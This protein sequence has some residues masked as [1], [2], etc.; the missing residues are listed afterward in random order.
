MVGKRKNYNS[1]CETCP[2]KSKKLEVRFGEF[3]KTVLS[4]DCRKQ[5]VIYI[6]FCRICRQQGCETLY[7]G[8]CKKLIKNRFTNA[9]SEL[10]NF[11]KKKSNRHTN[12]QTHFVHTHNITDPYLFQKEIEI[13]IISEPIPNRTERED[14]ETTWKNELK[15][16]ARKMTKVHVLNK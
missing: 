14:T 13:A 9:R 15:E 2:S 6:V 16:A 3:K 1:C 7:I 4:W 5:F 12:L 8:E 11:H 10:K